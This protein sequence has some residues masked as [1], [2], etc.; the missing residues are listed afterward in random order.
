MVLSVLLSR[1]RSF[2]VRGPRSFGTLYDVS[3]CG[4]SITSALD[5]FV[6]QQ[7]PRSLSVLS[8][9]D[10]VSLYQGPWSFLVFSRTSALPGFLRRPRLV[11]GLSPCWTLSHWI[12][13]RVFC[14][15]FCS[16]SRSFEVR[17]PLWSSLRRRRFRALSDVRALVSVLFSVRTPPILI[18]VPG[19]PGHCSDSVL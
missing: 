12:E 10:S 16:R 9:S 6:F 2:E 13:V 3:A 15:L 19:L 1:S 18:G 8:S 14:S 7:I 5:L 11:F 17:G 4:L